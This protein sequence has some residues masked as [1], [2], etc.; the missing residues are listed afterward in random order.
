MS[1]GWVRIIPEEP[2]FVP[3]Q[4]N[5]DRALAYFR[6]LAPSAEEISA[7]TAEH[8]VFRDCGGNFERVSCPSCGAELDMA[9]WRELMDA[10]YG[11]DGFALR[12]HEMVC[13]GAQHTL[14]ELRYEFQQGFGRFEMSA[15][16][17]NL[18]EL[19]E[20]QRREF[21]HLLGCQV[22]VIYQHL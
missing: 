9:D 21:E 10:D 3:E 6:V 20:S 13:C 19:S 5:Q 15:M 12:K 18:D 1:D 8:I 16:N 2:A 17:P 14:H 4:M 11:E 22:R 7:S